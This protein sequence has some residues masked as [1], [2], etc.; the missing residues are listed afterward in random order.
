ME[1]E[2][3]K[4]AP[5]KAVLRTYWPYVKRHPVLLAA[6]I[7]STVAMQGVALLAPWYLRQ[8]FNTLALSS[9]SDTA[10]A[11]LLSTLAIIAMLWVADRLLRRAEDN[12][13]IYFQARVMA[14]LYEDTFDYLLGHSYNFFVSN[15]AGS[16][17]HR[18]SRFA[19]AFDII[20]DNI[21]IQFLPTALFVSG[22]VVVLF[23]RNQWLGLALGVWCVF[24][25]W[26]QIFIGKVR[27]PIRAARSISPA[28]QSS[29]PAPP[30]AP[31]SPPTAR[32]R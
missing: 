27:Q 5:P 16:L 23:M 11:A 10:V 24:F 1:P 28:Q 26:F 18:V 13:Q 15:F 21:L 29:S 20:A 8:F 22:A 6:S 31:K 17:T 4:V 19:R 3:K 32:S 2:Q 12:A 14:E 30:P 25:V 7:L 9:P